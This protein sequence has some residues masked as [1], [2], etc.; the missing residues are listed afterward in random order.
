MIAIPWYFTDTLE[1][2]G[3]FGSIYLGVTCVSLFWSTIAGT[4]V[5]RYNRKR[6]F[7]MENLWGALTFLSIGIS[8]WFAG[9]VPSLPQIIVCF[10]TTFFIYNLHYPTL[11]AFSQEII[12]KENYSKISSWLEIQGQLTSMGAGALAAVLLSGVAG[13]PTQLFGLN[14][15]I[16]F[17][18]EAWS[19]SEI[20]IMDGITYFLSFLLISLIK[21]KAT[22]VRKIET[23]SI[24]Q[25]ISTGIRFLK[26]NPLLFI[27]G[28]AAYFIFVTIMV[29]NYLV[30]PNHIKTALGGTGHDY[31]LSEMFYA[32]GALGAGLSIRYIFNKTTTVFGNIAL[33]AL[34][35]IALLMLG[36][37][38]ELKYIF[39]ILFLLAISNSG[40]RIM[41]VIYLLEHIPNS[42][43]GRASSIFQIINVLQ[44][45]FFIGIFSLVYFTERTYLD[46][47]I[48]AFGVLIACLLLVY[49]YKGLVNFKTNWKEE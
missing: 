43:I 12:E 48:L 45:I 26:A 25:R 15:N 35:G 49:N 46:F 42:V 8:S 39:F 23:G 2:P 22:I 1:S 18:I 36:Y 16:P 41:R 11:Y 13:G 17:K 32:L 30:M 20:F 21:Y 7:Q 27:F 29:T 40:S 33:S 44:R 37:N 34:G 38:T 9:G 24:K 5:D 19:L 14:F 47:Y 4:L 10:A 28:N 31:A 6:L 3:L